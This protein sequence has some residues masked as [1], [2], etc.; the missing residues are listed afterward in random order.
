MME[1]MPLLSGSPLEGE[2]LL[3]RIVVEVVAGVVDSELKP[4]ADT[5]FQKLAGM[6]G[7][8]AKAII[9]SSC[10]SLKKLIEVSISMLQL[11][12]MR[13]GP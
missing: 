4:D 10:P 2:D 7:A 8:D 12:T 9:E 13:W 11:K 1:M 3:E 6:T 5:V